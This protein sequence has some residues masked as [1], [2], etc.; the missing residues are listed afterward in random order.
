MQNKNCE[1][2]VKTRNFVAT[3]QLVFHFWA[4]LPVVTE[5]ITEHIRNQNQDDWER[6][7]QKQI[8]FFGFG[9]SNF[10]GFFYFVSSW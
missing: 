9:F 5:T 4:A 8:F 2:V 10:F 6:L 3:F 1:N 7:K